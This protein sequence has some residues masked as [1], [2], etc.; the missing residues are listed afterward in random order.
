M[1]SGDGLYQSKIS[2]ITDITDIV[3]R[4]FVLSY[5]QVLCACMLVKYEPLTYNKTYVYP[6]WAICI[7]WLLTGCSIIWVPAYAIFRLV[8]EFPEGSLRKV[9]HLKHFVFFL[10]S[11]D[12]LVLKNSSQ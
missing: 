8:V 1:K 5:S 11:T 7:C 2:E 4:Q 3:S 10:C 6:T 9:G 12:S